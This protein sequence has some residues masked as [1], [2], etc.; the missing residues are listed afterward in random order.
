MYI[1]DLIIFFKQADESEIKLIFE[2]K[3]L[4]EGI[5]LTHLN[6]TIPTN[7]WPYCR[8]ITKIFCDYNKDQTIN[9]LFVK[10][11]NL[12]F[13]DLQS[14]KH[15]HTKK[16]LACKKHLILSKLQKVFKIF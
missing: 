9:K 15:Q 2:K 10:N 13:F 5:E 11:L 16:N 1:C 4:R 7:V 3:T 8:L 12:I 6:P 14:K